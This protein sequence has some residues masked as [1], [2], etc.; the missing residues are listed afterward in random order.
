MKGSTSHFCASNW[1]LPLL[2]LLLP[3]HHYSHDV[4]WL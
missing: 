1:P 4:P 3:V 2:L